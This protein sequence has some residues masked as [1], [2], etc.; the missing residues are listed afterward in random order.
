MLMPEEFLEQV[1]AHHPIARAAELIPDRAQAQLQA[2]RGAFDPKLA[3]SMRN[4][5][6]DDVL[7]YA[8]EGVKLIASTPIGLT[9]EAGFFQADGAYL[10]PEL[11]TPVGGQLG[12]AV[13][14]DVGQGLLIDER[15]MALRQAQLIQSLGDLERQQ[16]MNGLTADA[17]TAYWN[18][19]DAWHQARIL[20][21]S[22][23]LAQTRKQAVQIGAD[24]GDRPALDTLEAGIQ[25]LNR[26]QLWLDA[27][28][29]LL[30][31]AAR[32]D[33]YL[34]NEE[35]QAVRL[36]PDVVPADL[37]SAMTVLNETPSLPSDWLDAHPNL[38]AQENKLEQKEVELFWKKQ[39]LKPQLELKYQ[40]FDDASGF[41]E[42][43][44]W[45]A[46][47]SAFG[48]DFAFPLLL[49]KERGQIALTRVQLE[50]G[51]LELLRARR[52]FELTS[53]AARGA[54]PVIREQFL[55]QQRAIADAEKLLLG[56]R[57]LFRAGESS[58]F[59]INAREQYFIQAQLKGVEILHK[60]ADNVV[61]IQANEATW[62]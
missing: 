49:R 52:S 29:Q 23:A 30:Q 62:W 25:V 37:H 7:Y 12:A 22:M 15:R 21:E 54:Q 31:E 50:T 3:A 13:S 42:G 38:Q 14:W 44:S 2:A 8:E 10:N 59:L 33:A 47:R 56:E 34:W 53:A 19:F 32:L 4:K 1:W 61:S 39:Q 60:L 5:Q 28:Q 40:W 45:S 26:R 27:Q 20:E 46:N 36:Q 6:R 51:N 11:T 41:S 35:G 55:V 57:S 18:W 43:V 16:A 24:Q 58:L 48:L 17:L 9:A